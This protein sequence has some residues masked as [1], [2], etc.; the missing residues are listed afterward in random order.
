[1]QSRLVKITN[2]TQRKE[3]EDA[4][5]TAVGS[6]GRLKAVIAGL[7]RG[8]TNKKNKLWMICKPGKPLPGKREVN[9]WIASCKGDHRDGITGAR[10]KAKAALAAAASTQR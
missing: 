2:P 3:A 6:D 8:Q 1:M 10:A 4:Y 7:S 9:K 5:N